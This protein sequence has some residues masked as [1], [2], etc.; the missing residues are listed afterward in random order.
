MK[1]KDRGFTIIETVIIVIILSVLSAIAAVYVTGSQKKAR[2][3]KRLA[4]L[5]SIHSAVELFEAANWR[6]PGSPDS[7]YQS[8]H[9]P[10]WAKSTTDEVFRTDLA[11]YLT[12]LP[13]DPLKGSKHVSEEWTP[14]VYRYY[15]SGGKYKIDSGVEAETDRSASDGGI[16]NN[17]T[18]RGTTG[19]LNARYEFGTDLSLMNC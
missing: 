14:L 2:D 13:K 1:R 5:K 17:P 6:L 16:C 19:A 3:S 4:D 10:W 9:N 12:E 8:N 15:Q 7:W 18:P 11:P